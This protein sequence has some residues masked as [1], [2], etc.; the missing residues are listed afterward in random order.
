MA[1]KDLDQW[2]FQ[3]GTELQRLSEEM[4]HTGPMLARSA[5]WEPRIDLLES[6]THLILISDIAGV[7]GEDI[8]I[9]YSL[10]KHSLVIR[11]N[12]NQEDLLCDGGGAAH[13]LEIYYGEFEREIH[14]PDVEIQPE[15]IQAQYRNGLLI[16][17][18]PK[19]GTT[20]GAL[21]VHR[22]ITIQRL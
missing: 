16:V 11:G 17:L 14:L 3:L 6:S 2:L 8:R 10:D 21:R 15:S 5:K 22:T 4:T 7:R 1:R 13:Q 18:V 20:E 9:A 19:V 12:R